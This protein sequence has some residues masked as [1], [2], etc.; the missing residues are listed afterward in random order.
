MSDHPYVLAVVSHK[1]GA[2]RTTLASAMAWVWGQEG[3]QVTL[4]DADPIHAAGLLALGAQGKCSWP[5]VLYETA[6]PAASQPF[7]P[8]DV[9]VMDCPALLTPPAHEILNRVDGVLL[10]V[11]ADPMSLR[12]VAVAANEIERGRKSNPRLELLGMVVNIY[13]AQNDVQKTLLEQLRKAHGELLILP[14]IPQQVSFRLWPSKPGAE[15]P[16]G[17]AR[18]AIAELTRTIGGEVLAARPA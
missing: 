16:A 8:C 5:N 12:T 10:T 7:P 15:P 18:D 9:V 2:G 17:P 13:N 14:A 1:G 3:L 11:Q 6:V 4:L